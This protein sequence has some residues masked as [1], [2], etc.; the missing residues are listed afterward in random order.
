MFDH[1]EYRSRATP[2][3]NPPEALGRAGCAPEGER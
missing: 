1:V 2:L 3:V